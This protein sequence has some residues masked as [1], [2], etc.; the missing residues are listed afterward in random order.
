MDNGFC[1]KTS[2]HYSKQW[3]KELNYG[4]FVDNNA[5]AV[6]V[7]PGRQ[8]PWGNLIERI[9]EQASQKTV[10]VYDAGCGFGDIMKQLFKAPTPS[11]LNYLG[12][13]IH[14]ALSD[15]P[16][17]EGATLKQWNMA[18]PL[19]ENKKFD[20]IF[21]RAALHHTPDPARSYA[22]LASQLAAG[23]TLAVSVYAKKA[24][25]R[26]AIDD[27]LRDKIIPLGPDD[28]FKLVNQFT[29]LGRDLQAA[30]GIISIKQDLPFLGIKAGEYTIQEFIY[31]H[32]MKCWYN[33]NFSETHCDLINYDWYHPPYAYRF[34]LE[35]F[36][37]LVESNGLH[38]VK[39]ASIKAQ[40][41]IEAIK[42]S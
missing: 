10:H 29:L 11:M 36:K 28:A 39:T 42:P 37:D 6:M 12:A 24:P 15:L 38:I 17:P 32:F 41:Y 2:K 23:G 4:G 14:E 35:E 33:Q 19:I 26:E 40:H 7:M 16:C 9:R 31:D 20:F 27:A 13:D 25:M 21:C 1:T 8:L 34:S 3:G 5:D 18:E 30:D 22:T